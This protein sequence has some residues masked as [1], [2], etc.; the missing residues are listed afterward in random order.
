M[1]SHE[2]FSRDLCFFHVVVFFKEYTSYHL[3]RA[4][5]PV[6]TSLLFLM[7]TLTHT[8]D[9]AVQLQ[10]GR[11]SGVRGIYSVFTALRYCILFPI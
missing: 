8:D 6:K 5:T 7:N 4:E 11:R 1:P 9:E 3:I 10:A 2:A